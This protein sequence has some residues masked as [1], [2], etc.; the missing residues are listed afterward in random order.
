MLLNEEVG[1]DS[2]SR[3]L[4]TERR[5]CTFSI[6]FLLDK[7]NFGTLMG[8][9]RANPS[10]NVQLTIGSDANKK[11]RFVMSNAEWDFTSLDLPDQ[12]MVRVSMSGRALGT[13][14]NDSVKLRI[15]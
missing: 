1:L 5:N 7:D 6:A 12:D 14:G 8:D 11:F 3:V 4:R 15:L 2:A 9:M 10:K 13:N